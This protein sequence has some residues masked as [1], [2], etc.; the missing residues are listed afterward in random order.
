M[1]L[2]LLRHILEPYRKSPISHFSQKRKIREN[3]N[4]I[5]ETNPFNIRI[6][7]KEEKILSALNSMEN[8]YKDNHKQ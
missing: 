2:N 3:N 7:D 8:T 4:S 6:M 1:N 5:T